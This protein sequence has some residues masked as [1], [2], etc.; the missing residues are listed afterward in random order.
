MDSWTWNYWG[1]VWL[2]KKTELLIF[3]APK[4]PSQSSYEAMPVL[5]ELTGESVLLLEA[6]GKVRKN[7]GAMDKR[8]EFLW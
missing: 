2:D 3:W 5:V 6:S 7:Q 8:Q 1:Y 4:N